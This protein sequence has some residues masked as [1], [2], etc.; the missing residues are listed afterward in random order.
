MT[1]NQAMFPIATMCKSFVVSRAGYYAWLG[2]EPSALSIPAAALHVGRKRVERLMN[3]GKGCAPDGISTAALR[4][5]GH[6]SI[7]QI[8]RERKDNPPESRRG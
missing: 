3:S 5:S 6:G 4:G 1:A 7:S 2:R 8:I